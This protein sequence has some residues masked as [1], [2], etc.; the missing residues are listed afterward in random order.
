MNRTLLIALGVVATVVSSFVGLVAIPQEQLR[1]LRPIELDDGS[2]RPVEPFGAVAEGREVYIDLGCIYCHSQQMRPSGYGADVERGWG[3]RQTVP[4]DHIYDQPPLLGTMRTGPDLANIGVRQ[5]SEQWHYLH[6][7]D[8]ELTSPG[9]IMPKL[10]F[11]FERVRKGDR[12]EPPPDAL[13]LPPDR[14]PEEAWIVP[15]RRARALVAYLKS[16]DHTYPVPEGG[17]DGR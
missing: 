17:N 9:S 2:E 10:P 11:L 8:P 6:L 5:P 7:Y 14:A 12:A 4:R 1:A 13:D 15:G 3:T 16:L